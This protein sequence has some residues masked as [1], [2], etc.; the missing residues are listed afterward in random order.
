MT[1][2]CD[3][4]IEARIE[5]LSSQLAKLAERK[6]AA[7]QRVR[8]LMAAEDVRGGVTYA[9]EIFEAKQE[10]LVLET[11]MEIARRQRNRLLMPQ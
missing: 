3:P 2:D 7:E 9:Q 10:K 4:E 5:A 1:P 11:E 8:E 6:K